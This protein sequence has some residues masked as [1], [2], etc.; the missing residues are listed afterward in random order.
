MNL[1]SLSLRSRLVG[2]IL[3]A[4]VPVM[5]LA[6][7]APS[8]LA[9]RNMRAGANAE[10]SNVAGDLANRVDSWDAT[11]VLLLRGM[12]QSPFIKTMDPKVQRPMLQ[13]LAKVYD[14]FYLIGVTPADGLNVARADDRPPI[15]YSDRQWFKQAM[16]GK[17][18]SRQAVISRT[19]SLPGM[20][21][22]VP[23]HNGGKTLGVVMVG[24]SL[25]N[26][27]NEVGA[28]KLGERGYAFVVDDQG[29]LVTR[30]HLDPAEKLQNYSDYP[31]VK[32]L[33]SGKRGAFSFT[34]SDGVH[35]LAHLARAKNGW[36]TISLEPESE[37]LGDAR[38]IYLLAWISAIA[39]IAVVVGFTWM[40]ATRFIRPVRDITNAAVALAD[41]KWNVPVTVHRG[42]E[43]GVLA[44]AFNRM[45]EHMQRAYQEIEERVALRTEELRRSNDQLRAAREAADSAN[46]AKDEFLANMSHELRTPLTTILGYV[47]LLARSDETPA[48]QQAH[49]AS[50]QGSAHHLLSIINEVLDLS[51][52]EAG[53]MTI[54]LSDV[55]IRQLVGDVVANFQPRAAE[56][57]LV[58]AVDYEQSFPV[59]IRSDAKRLQQILLNLAGNAIKFTERGRVDLHLAFDKDNSVVRIV[60]KDTGIGL[61]P[62]QVGRLFQRFAQMDS[63]PSRRFPGTGL[64]LFIS[65]RLARMLGGD[66]TVTSEEGKGS[67][68]VLTIAAEVCEPS[69]G[70]LPVVPPSVPSM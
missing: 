31:P 65:R 17:E 43:I 59:C 53:M 40:I 48:S 4:T 34:D 46:R 47:D 62:E 3:L 27:S 35:W 30:P 64:G 39:A 23:I 42:D 69:A 18:V 49:L 24:T 20:I 58:L 1:R 68:F 2:L 54:K 29:M 60:V 51:S 5:A 38:N 61:R 33:F 6:I 63:S 28:V 36:G 21:V 22:A 50:I 9:A 66:I 12:S 41:R 14:Q 52:I 26:L 37:V 16:A 11:I 10:L 13:R 15:D 7:L 67:S 55:N 70:E 19:T 32:A 44:S 57:N 56:K 45:I 25:N 8:W